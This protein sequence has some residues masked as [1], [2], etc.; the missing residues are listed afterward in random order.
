MAFQ[1]LKGTEREG[2]HQTSPGFLL[3]FIAY[4]THVTWRSSQKQAS[5][6]FQVMLLHFFSITFRTKSV[7][8]LQKAV[9]TWG[10]TWAHIQQSNF[11]R[12][13]TA[14]LLLLPAELCM[15]TTSRCCYLLLNY[16]FRLEVNEVSL[17]FLFTFLLFLM[18]VEKKLTELLALVGAR[19][20][21]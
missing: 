13:P 15:S 18:L 16:E 17:F 4:C 19:V 8:I 10:P 2:D 7:R 1:S 21:F 11:L 6:N 12:S 3:S 5:N 9:V 20:H 14:A